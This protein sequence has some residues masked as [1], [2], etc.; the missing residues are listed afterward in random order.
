MSIAMNVTVAVA[1]VHGGGAHGGKAAKPRNTRKFT[2]SSSRSP[3]AAA[4][5][6]QALLNATVA[7]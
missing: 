7:A 6:R 3:I 4:A 1:L 5:F 2:S